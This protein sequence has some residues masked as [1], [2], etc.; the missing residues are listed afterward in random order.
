MNTKTI[1]GLNCYI[2]GKNSSKKIFFWFIDSHNSVNIEQIYSNLLKS[3]PDTDFLLVACA[4]ANWNDDLSPW[5]ADSVFG[6]SDF[7]G[8]GN[9]TLNWLKT[10]CI[11]YILD[12]YNTDL[13]DSSLFIGGYSL[14]GL[15]SLWAFYELKIFNG[16]CACSS[17]MWFP[18]W[19]NYVLTHTTPDNCIIY[20]SLGIKEEKT[21]NPTMS[22]V[23]NVTRKIYEHYSNDSHVGKCIL[24]WNNGNHFTEI[25]NRIFKGFSWLLNNC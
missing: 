11:P 21:K 2:C 19:K 7:S 17:S 9:K 13:S 14:A 3:S 22:T 16:V 15:F 6:D 23:G 1:D 18:G 8:E 24:E 20:L 12:L 25:E 4:V 10:S 5:H